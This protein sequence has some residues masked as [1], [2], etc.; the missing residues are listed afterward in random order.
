MSSAPHGLRLSLG[1][2][3]NSY[4]VNETMFDTF[5]DN[6]QR[7]RAQ[8]VFE[9]LNATAKGKWERTAVQETRDRRD[10][11]RTLISSMLS[12]RTREEDTRTATNNLFTLAKTPEA[13]A[14][15]SEQQ[16]HTAIRMVTYPE[17]KVGYVQQLSQQL[18][19]EHDGEVPRDLASLTALP[20]VGWKTGVLT[21]W[22]AFGIAEEICV[23][24]HVA[25]I[26]KRLGL[27][28]RKTKAPQKV[29]REL[30]AIV[31]EDIWGPW[32]PMMVRF[33]R[34]VCYPQKPNCTACPLNDIC[35][36]I[37]V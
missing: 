30:M 28:D 25:R 3:V 12:A 19:G 7:A 27:V 6:E 18:V 2:Y 31:P 13:M 24:V 8:T 35:P 33:G 9:R 32:N 1:E 23:D 22:I 11:F 29:S 21:Q 10:P 26:G 37:D 36:K 34:E 16:I 20:G 14:Q 17:P 15:L 4:D 5:F